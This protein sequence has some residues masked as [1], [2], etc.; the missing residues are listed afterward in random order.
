VPVAPATGELGGDPAIGNTC[1]RGDRPLRALSGRLDAA[2]RLA[3]PALLVAAAIAA[4]FGIAVL[5][6]PATWDG[7]LA[8]ANGDR[9]ALRGWL[10]DLGPLAPVASLAVNVVQAVV[11]PIPGF[12]IP[13]INGAV[14]GMWPGALL[15][16]IGGMAGA[17]ACFGLARTAARPLAAR[18]CHGS[19][20]L[21]GAGA[22][23][24][25]HSGVAVLAV[26]LLPGSPFDLVS[27]LC[28]LIG[29]RAW[30]FLWGTAVGSAPHALAYAY[31]G[32]AF[33]VPIWAG[34]ALTPV[35][36]LAYLAAVATARTVMRMARA[37]A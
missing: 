24:E 5:V 33:E 8:L 7:F 37:G 20:G 35:L 12:V 29:M 10:Q 27:Y 2:V 16:W 13:Y 17:M 31:L 22:R 15:T 28:G 14:F 11:A 30:P 3:A 36:G 26:R 19:K 6:H 23:L 1:A 18:L 34:L 25:R 32:S 21:G 9:E 4:V